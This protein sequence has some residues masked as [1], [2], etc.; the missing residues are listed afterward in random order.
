MGK[1]APH[2][3]SESQEAGTYRLT[4]FIYELD[5]HKKRI[6]LKNTGISAE[7]TVSNGE[8]G[9]CADETGISV[10]ALTSDDIST[11]LTYEIE[12][13]IQ[14]AA[15]E[16]VQKPDLEEHAFQA[17][18]RYAHVPSSQYGT[19]SVQDP[20]TKE[21]IEKILGEQKEDLF[22]AMKEMQ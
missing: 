10:T 7:F 14:E 18:K 1:A 12:N 22:E 8:E 2:S 15:Q 20:V 9:D 3:H 13:T 17:D 19:K 5:G 11:D 16:A 4:S 6:D 21:Q